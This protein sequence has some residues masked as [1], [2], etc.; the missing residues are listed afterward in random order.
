MIRMARI[1]SGNPPVEA[2]DLP[3]WVALALYGATWLGVPV[4]K[5]HTITG[6]NVGVGA[7]RGTHAVKWGVA[8]R[9][10]WAW[11]LSIPASAPVGAGAWWLFS[12]AGWD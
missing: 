9:V 6:A 2:S 5:T 10:V 7:T 11:V 3:L 8:T 4:S 1:A 12:L